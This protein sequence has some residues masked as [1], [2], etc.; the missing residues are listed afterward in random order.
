MALIGYTTGGGDI[1]F[2]VSVIHGYRRLVYRLSSMK[3]VANKNKASVIRYIRLRSMFLVDW[4][5]A[6][7]LAHL[8]QNPG[9]RASLSDGKQRSHMNTRYKQ[10]LT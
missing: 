5:P 10:Q 6:S 4:V 1:S 8:Q 9:K 7:H 3:H 2:D